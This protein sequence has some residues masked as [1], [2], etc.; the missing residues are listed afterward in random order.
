MSTD[1]RIMMHEQHDI[2]PVSGRLNHSLT[3]FDAVVSTSDAL[4]AVGLV[5][6]IYD[7]I[8]TARAEYTFFWR[9]KSSAAGFLFFANRY[10][11][12]LSVFAGNY[13]AYSPTV[14]HTSPIM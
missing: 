9:R 6:M 13:P 10:A 8:L 7:H 4:A 2:S 12:L 5:A 3:K 11:L 1:G 14:S